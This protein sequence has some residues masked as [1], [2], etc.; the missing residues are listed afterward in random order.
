MPIN[1][2][3]ERPASLSGPFARPLRARRHHSRRPNLGTLLPPVL[4]SL[5]ALFAYEALQ[6]RSSMTQVLVARTSIAVGQP[7]SQANTAVISLHSSD[8]RLMRG[9]LSAASP[10]GPWVA[11]INMRPGEPLTL[12]AVIQ[13]SAGNQLGEMSIPVPQDQAV[14]GNLSVGDA[15]DVIQADTSG[16]AKYV[17]QG[18]TVVAVARG[19]QAGLLG[20]AGAGSDFYITVSVTKA[21]ALRIAAALG[22]SSSQ[23]GSIEIVSSTG[24]PETTRLGMRLPGAASDGGIGS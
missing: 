9:L 4:A 5:A 22:A 10:R 13:P 16:G 8:V 14:G 11:A 19:A 20:Q 1:Q 12:G 3:A 23:A 15:V 18:L 17:A 2:V 21:D 24:E 6:D 7:I